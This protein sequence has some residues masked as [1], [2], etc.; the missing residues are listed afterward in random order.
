M[1]LI[2]THPT[3][4]SGLRW[5]AGGLATGLALAAFAGPA[6]TVAQAQTNDGETIRSISVTGVG[7]V[8]AEPDVADVNLGVT[9]QGEDAQ[10]AAAEAA[11]TMDAVINALLEAG[12]A[13]SDIQTTSLSLYAVYDYNDNPPEIEGWEARN[14]VNAT[15]RDIESVGEVV[16]AATAAGATDVTGISFRVDDPA[17]AEAEAR[18][19]AVAD[20]RVKADQL[21]ADAGVTIIGVVSISESG[22]QMPQPIYME[23]AA[24]DMAAAEAIPTTPV[25]PGQVEL[26]ISVFIQYEISG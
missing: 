7:R 13:E 8:K 10:A 2:T 12:V 14:L 20:A 25:L 23:R 19:A 9:K 11:T 17:A 18:S 1:A 6:T 5:L 24:F 16:D 4:R 15:V 22:A 26:S 3:S 21:A